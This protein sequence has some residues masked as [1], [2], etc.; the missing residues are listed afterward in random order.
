[1]KRKNNIKKFAVE[2]LLAGTIFSLSSCLKNGPYDYDFAGAGASVYLPLA[3]TNTNNPV[4]FSYAATAAS[5]S[6][7]VYVDL[8]SPKTLS[9]STSVT[10][11]VD[12]AYLNQF[13]TDNGTAYLLM[14]SDAYTTSGWDLT[15]PA[16][17]RLDS[18]LVTFDFNKLDLSQSY[19]LPVTIVD[20]SQPIEQWNHLMLNIVVKNQFDGDYATTG[21]VFHPSV[22]RAVDDVYHIGTAGPYTC[23]IPY[24]DLG[25]SNYY[26]NATINGTSGI[27]SLINYAPVGAAPASSGF[28]TA[29]NPGAIDYSLALPDAP[30]KAP[31]L[32]STYN[33]TYNYSTQTFLVHVGYITGGSLPPNQN[34]FSRQ[35]YLKFVKQ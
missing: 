28:M 3:A 7:P 14:P 4:V 19:I 22:P 32:S 1:M 35:L 8:A 6:I 26:F 13:N 11:A 12:S 16:G 33:N 24:G 25:S 29:D 27:V 18:M 20:A 21:Y 34:E 10:L 23:T 9:T 2:L 15:I 17:Q 31:W 5:P 30:G